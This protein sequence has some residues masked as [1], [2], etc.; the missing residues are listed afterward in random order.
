M[1]PKFAVPFLAVA[2]AFLAAVLAVHFRGSNPAGPPVV[3]T[4][5]PLAPSSPAPKPAVS[6]SPAI[7]RPQAGP[8]Q[9]RGATDSPEYMAWLRENQSRLMELS[10]HDDPESLQA[11]LTELTSPD[12]HIRKTALTATRQFG[13]R[14]AIPYLQ[15]LAERT[16]DAREKVKILD[17]IGFLKMPSLTEFRQAQV[18]A[19]AGN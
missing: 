18:K 1:R 12:P 9:P 6:A 13:G 11:I 14:D 2:A 4:E 17:T 19:A 15:A 8:E 5:A 3:V 16:D 7:V 10:A